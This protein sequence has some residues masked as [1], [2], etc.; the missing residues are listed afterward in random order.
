MAEVT[1]GYV[2]QTNPNYIIINLGT[3]HNIKVGDKIGIYGIK[4]IR[5]DGIEIARLPYQKATTVVKHANEDCAYLINAHAISIAD[6]LG[7]IRDLV[8]NIHHTRLE[9]PFDVD[10]NEADKPIEFDP[11]IRLGDIARI[12]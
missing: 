3:S 6:M 12:L 7:G 2:I 5:S 11:V 4:S 10:M 8:D 1:E 9:V